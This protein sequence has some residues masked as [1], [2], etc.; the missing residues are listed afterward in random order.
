MSDTGWYWTHWGHLLT[1]PVFAAPVYAFLQVWHAPWL[2]LLLTVLGFAGLSAFRKELLF[3]LTLDWGEDWK[4]LVIDAWVTATP[5]LLLV[6]PMGWW[7]LVPLGMAL[8]V[9]KFHT[10]AKP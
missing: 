2:A 6:L 7:W 3:P 8:A 10:W 4:D 9:L 1:K 5:F